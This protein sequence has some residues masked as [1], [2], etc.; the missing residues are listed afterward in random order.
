ML[1]ASDDDRVIRNQN[2]T[3]EQRHRIATA[4]NKN[5]SDIDFCDFQGRLVIFYSWGNQE[6]IEHLAEAVYEGTTAQFLKGWF[7]A[8]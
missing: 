3:P 7:P 5:N 2:L 8:E 1:K 4:V 6:G